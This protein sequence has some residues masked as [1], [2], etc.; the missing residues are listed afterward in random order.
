MSR[1]VLLDRAGNIVRRCDAPKGAPYLLNLR[2]GHYYD[3]ANR[4]TFVQRAETRLDY[5]SAK[6]PTCGAFPGWACG[7]DHTFPLHRAR[8]V[9]AL[10][11]CTTHG[12][13]CAE[14]GK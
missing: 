12:L 4:T 13:G 6:C 11:Q 10:R 14:E 2:D 1:A 7:P 9:A 8:I 5:T 3:A